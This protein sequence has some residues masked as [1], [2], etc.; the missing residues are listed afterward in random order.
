MKK[1][2]L[3]I[4][5]AILAACSGDMDH[6]HAD[7][8]K[9]SHSKM[10]QAKIGQGIEISSP[11]V[12]PPFPGKDVAAGFFEVKNFGADDRLIAVSSPISDT[13]EIHNH[14]EENGVMKMRK[15]DGVDLPSGESIS[16]K[17][18][19]YHLMMFGANIP[20][21]QDDVALT[22]TYE[23]APSVTIIVPIG[24]PA[25]MDHSNH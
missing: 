11:Y 15:I 20:E 3:I 19:S 7:G 25:E 17:P 1:L 10:D 4:T 9:M 22:L 2:S 16:F 13:V 5:A 24:E 6:N 18:G 12:M 23:T 14:I 21:A 8:D